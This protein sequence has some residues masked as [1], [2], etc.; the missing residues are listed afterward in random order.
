M[1][2]EAKLGFLLFVEQPSSAANVRDEEQHNQWKL[3]TEII[4]LL[5]MCF[6]DFGTS[7]FT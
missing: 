2:R 5:W 3:I 4:V 1:G 6:K 7:M